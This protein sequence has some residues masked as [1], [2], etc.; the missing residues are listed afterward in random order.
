MIVLVK[1]E[2]FPDERAPL[3]ATNQ[4]ILTL[5]Q[6]QTDCRPSARMQ[7]QHSKIHNKKMA[8]PCVLQNAA[9]GRN[10]YP[11]HFPKG[12]LVKRV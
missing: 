9:K 6:A 11:E 8:V 4:V 7:Q 5:S 10:T 1:D 12:Y 3:Q 2:R